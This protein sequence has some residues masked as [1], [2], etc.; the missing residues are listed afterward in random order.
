VSVKTQTW[1]PRK[2]TTTHWSISSALLL[3]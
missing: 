3:F 1:I 2:N